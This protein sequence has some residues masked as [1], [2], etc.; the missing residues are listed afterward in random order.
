MTRDFFSLEIWQLLEYFKCHISSTCTIS[1]GFFLWGV[2]TVRKSTTKTLVRMVICVSYMVYSQIW[3]NLS[4][5]EH[6]FF[7]ILL[8]MIATLAKKQKIRKKTLIATALKLWYYCKQWIQSCKGYV[9][10][11]LIHY[12]DSQP[13]HAALQSRKHVRKV[14][15]SLQ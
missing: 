4:K 12:L 2:I 9:H 3:L 5:E 14:K 10:Y 7:C 15:W 11:S 6:H 1:T 13:Y 8:W